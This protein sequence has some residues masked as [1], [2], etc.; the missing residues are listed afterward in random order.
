MK[1]LAITFFTAI[2]IIGIALI[3]DVASGKVSTEEAGLVG[4]TTIT[5]DSRGRVISEL[6][7][8][9]NGKE[10]QETSMKQLSYYDNKNEAV[11]YKKVDGAWM[12]TSKV[13]TETSNGVP[14]CY[15]YFVSSPSGRWV[16]VAEQ[17]ADDLSSNDVVDDVVFDAEGNLVMKATYVYKDGERLG[18]QKEEYGYEDNTQKTRVFYAWNGDSWNKMVSAKVVA[19]Q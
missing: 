18:L 13:V 8:A 12:A 2:A 19:E 5:R 6:T 14:V 3:C 4:K 7:V 17:K 11:T 9:I 1:T 16:E 10:W 15:S